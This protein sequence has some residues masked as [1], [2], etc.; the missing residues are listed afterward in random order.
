[1]KTRPFKILRPALLSVLAWFGVLAAGNAFAACTNAPTGLINWW[2]GGGDATD[3]VGGNNGT[4]YG[5]ATFTSGRVGQ[6]FT[7]DG[8]DD[9]VYIGPSVGDFGTSDFTI[10]FWMKTTSTRWEAVMGKRNA[11]R[12]YG[13]WDI[14]TGAM[15]PDGFLDFELNYGDGLNVNLISATPVNNGNWH[16]V[17]VV[18]E[19]TSVLVY[20]DGQLDAAVSVGGISDVYNDAAFVMGME[21]ACIGEDGTSRFTGQLDEISLY[22]RALSDAEIQEIFNAGADG[23]CLPQTAPIIVKQPEGGTATEGDGVTFTV[24][25][26]GMPPLSF[27]WQLNGND[28]LGATSPRLVLPN[29]QLSDAGDYSVMVSNSFGVTPSSNATLTVNPIRSCAP[30]P[31]GLINWWRG[32]GDAADQVGSANGTLLNGAS[33]SATGKVGQGFILDGVDD[34]VDFGTDAGNFGTNDFSVEFWVKTTSTRVEAVLGKRDIC[35]WAD[36]WDIRMGNGS[37]MLGVEISSYDPKARFWL[38]TPPVND[39]NWHHIVLVR[40]RTEGKFYVDGKCT[41]T[42]HAAAVANLSNGT[43]FTIGAGACVGVDGTYPFTG[44]M[45]EVSLYNRALCA[46]EIRELYD[47]RSNGKCPDEVAPPS[48]SCGAPVTLTIVTNGYGKIIV[49][50]GQ[51]KAGVTYHLIAVPEPHNLLS[52]WVCIVN[53]ITNVIT[54]PSAKVDITLSGDTIMIAN[55]VTNRLA[56]AQGTYYGLF[57]DQEQ[58]VSRQSAGFFTLKVA[59]RGGLSGKLMLDGDR[60]S[61]TVKLNP[62]I[63]SGTTTVNR[64]GKPALALSLQLAL[65]DTERVTGQLDNATD[66]WCAELLGDHASRTTNM[67]ERYT[68][69]LPGQADAVMPAGDG[70]STASVTANR[71]VKMVGKLGDGQPFTPVAATISKDGF[72]PLYASPSNQA[73]LGWVHFTNAPQR[74]LTG[75]LVWMRAGSVNG[76]CDGSFTNGIEL[77]ASG[78]TP[79]AYKQRG[80]FITNGTIILNEGNLP[81]PITNQLIISDA[82]KFKLI[83]TNG[84]MKSLAFA[85]ASGLLKAT[86]VH[87]DKPGKPTPVSGIYLQNQNYGGG[88]FVGTN[89]TGPLLLKDN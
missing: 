48:A 13:G 86:F 82:N 18:R 54:T 35:T 80:I 64:S 75:D 42:R 17:A 31:S 88:F 5:G 84:S 8:I 83:T 25:A 66:G 6:G 39:G 33:A 7:F 58:G 73:V 3:I 14:R 71:V 4:L 55:F 11:C 24:G 38:L 77:V 41:V 72:F 23:K 43:S 89:Q 69:L 57:S 51:F 79:P 1:M 59:E 9:Y 16:H 19:Q 76:V 44:Q 21:T 62:L 36:Q 45:D 47:A 10:E 74:E 28:L 67:L 61:F 78:Y 85:P 65:D 50:P 29:V 12:D 46:Y 56:K 37:G 68:L 30:Q 20:V 26:A 2:W 81:N 70:Y 53:G 49:P 22:G 60:T 87:P 40:M 15:A 32:E 63:G 27:Q 52:N 34:V